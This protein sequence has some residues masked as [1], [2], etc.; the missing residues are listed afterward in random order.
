MSF[1]EYLVQGY[2][3]PKFSANRGNSGSA[4]HK[5]F[6]RTLV[7]RKSAQLRTHARKHKE[8]TYHALVQWRFDPRAE[9]KQPWIHG[10][11]KTKGTTK[12][13]SN[14]PEERITHCPRIMSVQRRAQ[15]PWVEFCRTPRASAE[16]PCSQA[17]PTTSDRELPTSGSYLER[18]MAESV[19]HVVRPKP[20]CL[21]ELGP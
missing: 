4:E 14:P 12:L 1:V 19:D 13:T 5:W 20:P 16:P 15:R 8:N 9:W 3:R 2:S 17:S 11:T 6:G 10:P 18:G 21:A 7:E